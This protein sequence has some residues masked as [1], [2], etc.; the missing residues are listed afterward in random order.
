[1]RPE[2]SSPKPN[3]VGVGNVVR[4]DDELGFAPCESHFD[5]ARVDLAADLE[6]GLAE[7]VEQMEMER[8]S[9]RVA[10]AASGL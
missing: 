3:W 5:A 1:M 8:R 4:D 9:E 6:S 7:E 2:D 10:H